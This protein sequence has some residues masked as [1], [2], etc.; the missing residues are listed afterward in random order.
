MVIW[1]TWYTKPIKKEN[2]FI[3]RMSF[4]IKYSF[5]T[6]G[7]VKIGTYAESGKEITKAIL[8]KGEVF[9][10]LAMIGETVKARF[11]TRNGRNPCLYHDR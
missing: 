5:L 9:G 2:I 10:E 6:D 11:C 3:Y 1:S 8:G 7:R 4:L